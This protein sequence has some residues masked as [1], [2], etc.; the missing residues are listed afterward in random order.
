MGNRANIIT[1]YVCNYGQQYFNWAADEV[2]QM[3]KDNEVD[4][5]TANDHDLYCRWEI[6]VES[7][8]EYLQ[9]LEQLP[10][11][12]IHENFKKH[13]DC[14]EYTNQAVLNDLKEWLPFEDT[15]DSII[16]LDWF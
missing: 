9:Q 8:K 15:R 13:D 12:D 14:K 7:F 10:P 5:W 3:L 16:R 1:E 2:H 11:D 4:V 6:D